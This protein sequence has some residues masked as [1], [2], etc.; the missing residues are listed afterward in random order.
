MKDYCIQRVS[1]STMNEL[2]NE[3]NE[4]YAQNHHLG[5]YTARCYETISDYIPNESLDAEEATSV[6]R[7]MVNPRDGMG[8]SC[9]EGGRAE[10][11]NVSWKFKSS[12]PCAAAN[13][14]CDEKCHSGAESCCCH[15]QLCETSSLQLDQDLKLVDSWGIDCYSRT[16]IQLILSHYSISSYTVNAF[17]QN[18]LLPTISQ[19]PGAYASDPA[20]RNCHCVDVIVIVFCLLVIF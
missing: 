1:L 20:V 5:A 14:A 15:N 13:R 7:K 8:C 17:I 10:L 9:V 4:P 16:L 12:C 11:D 2:I 18:C 3:D 19:I 6:W